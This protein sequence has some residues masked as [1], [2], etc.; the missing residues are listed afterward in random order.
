MRNQRDPTRPRRRGQH[1]RVSQAL[2]TVAAFLTAFPAALAGDW[3]VDVND[4]ACASGTGGTSDPFCSIADAVAVAAPGDT[5]HIA[6]GIYFENLAIDKDLTLIGTGGD[7]VT[8]VDG[9]ASGRVFNIPTT[10]AP[11]VRIDGLTITNGNA[12]GHQNGGGIQVQNSA[13]LILSNSTV[14]NNVADSSSAYL[15]RGGGIANLGTS[16][17]TNCVVAGNKATTATSE[18]SG[19]GIFNGTTGTVTMTNCTVSGNLSESTAYSYDIADSFASGGGIQNEGALVLTNCAVQGNAVSAYAYSYGFFSSASALAYGGGI[20]QASGTTTLTGCTVGGNSIEAYAYSAFN[21]AQRARG[22][23]IRR[24][25]GTLSVGHSILAKNTS[26]ESHPDA[27]G[28]V[29]SLGHNLIGINSGASW[30]GD[31]SGNQLNVD[32]QFASVAGGDFRLQSTSPAMDAG[33][34]L[35][36]PCSADVLG[37]S[38]LLDGDLDGAATIDLGAYEFTHVRLGITGIPTFGQDLSVDVTGTPGLQTTLLVGFPA[39][40]P[41]LFGQFGCLQVSPVAPAWIVV[42][43]GP[44]PVS[45]AATVPPDLE[46][47]TIITQVIATQPG[48]GNLSNAVATTFH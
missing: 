5:I 22:G 38:R 45:F 13:T 31:L 42:P 26:T 14:S 10:N 7:A 23:G 40:V 4:A 20:Q 17:L 28:A 37:N 46:G 16:I 39:A 30:S 3:Y 12:P 34:P 18:S 9:S 1:P 24:A 48:A 47:L 15:A 33:D 8:T 2:L 29:T 43:L 32:P 36:R 44:S 27:S 21:A 35:L 25:S 19:G 6:P 41:A 11:T